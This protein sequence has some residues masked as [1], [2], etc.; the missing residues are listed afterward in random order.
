MMSGFVATGVAYGDTLGLWETL[1]KFDEPKTVGEISAAANLKERYVK[2]WMGLMVVGD[3]IDADSTGSRF[4]LPVHRRKYLTAEGDLQNCSILANGLQ[5]FLRGFDYA[6]DAAKPSGPD[7]FPQTTTAL[8][9]FRWMD[10]FSEVLMKTTLLSKFVPSIPGFQQSLDTGTSVLSVCCGSAIDSIMLAKSF[11]KTTFTG[12]DLDDVALKRAKTSA[13]NG[14]LQNINFEKHDAYQL[15]ADWSNQFDY[16]TS[17][18][19]IHDTGRPD[20]VLGEIHRVLKPGGVYVMVEYKA[21][22]TNVT[23]N[24][25]RPMMEFLYCASLLHC[26]PTS[27]AQEGGI[28]A[29]CCWGDDTMARFLKE[30]GFESVDKQPY[31]GFEALI[32]F[33]CKK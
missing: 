15:P 25:G 7:G 4:F 10:S 19:S 28:G 27:L 13:A 12:I 18:Y 31:P 9:F 17:V 6:V 21:S 26:V 20:L 14:S 3:I 16:V 23:E 33:I 24:K 8:E 11:P 5:F 1:A 32:C 30:A 29:G 2:E 22:S